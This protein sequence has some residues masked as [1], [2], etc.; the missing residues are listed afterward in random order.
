MDYST[1]PPALIYQKKTLDKISGLHELNSIVLHNMLDIETLHNVDFEKFALPCF[2]NAYYICTMMRME[3]NAEYRLNEY[4][5]IALNGN[6]Q[7][8]LAQCVTLSLVAILT[9]HCLQPWREKLLGISNRL[10]HYATSL[11]LERKNEILFPLS[12]HGDEPIYNTE[13]VHLI[14]MPKAMSRG[15]D[16]NIVLP[17]ELFA[18]RPID[19]KAFRDVARGKN[20]FEWVYWTNYYDEDIVRELVEGLGTTQQDKAMLIR[21]LWETSISYYENDYPEEYIEPLLKLLAEEFCPDCLQITNL[22][23]DESTGTTTSETPLPPPQVPTTASLVQ[24]GEQQSIIEQQATRIKEL[25]A[26]VEYIRSEFDE[27]KK[28]IGT[29]DEWYTGEYKNLPEDVNMVLRERVVFFA[30]VLSLDLD[31]KYTVLSN[32]AKFICKICNDQHNV[33]PFLSRMKKAEEAEA[34]A[35]AAKKVA[36]LMKGILPEEYQNNNYLKIN[37][38]VDSMLLNFPGKEEE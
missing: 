6:N 24:D 34:N 4:K 36:G 9:E 38:L 14:G 37:Q 3:K 35:K 25:E 26:E 12:S 31:K 21:S 13:M 10:K 29:Q 20:H 5:K 18:P 22:Y 8:T 11:W 33:G 19:E 32:L 23:P 28:K 2:N 30:T 15:I 1:L 17:D 7:N 16:E 27:A